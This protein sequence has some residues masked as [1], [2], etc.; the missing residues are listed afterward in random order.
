MTAVGFRSREVIQKQLD[1]AIAEQKRDPN[2]RTFGY[3]E[4]LVR[5]LAVLD[6]SEKEAKRVVKMCEP[7]ATGY[8]E[9][10]RWALGGE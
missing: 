8:R 7:K 5:A 2:P 10:I 3:I 6:D 1:D 9:A 4:G